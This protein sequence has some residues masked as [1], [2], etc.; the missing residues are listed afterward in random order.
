[1]ALAPIGAT[2]P[3]AP[4]GA[5]MPLGASFRERTGLGIVFEHFNIPIPFPRLIAVPKPTEV[6]Y[7]VPPTAPAGYAPPAMP[8]MPMA[9]TGYVVPQAP[10]CQAPAPAPQ[11]LSPQ[12]TAALLQ[13]L[14]NQ[15]TGTAPPPA[16]TAPVG[17]APTEVTD[18][19]CDEIIHKCNILKRLHQLK[20]HALDAACCPK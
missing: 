3:I 8:M 11:G 17:V 1:M 14:A 9:P 12:Q 4:V 6:T 19:Q 5:T 2:M 20:Q 13:L 10:V 18:Q 7:Q 15:P 16:P